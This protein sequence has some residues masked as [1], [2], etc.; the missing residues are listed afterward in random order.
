LNFVEVFEAEE[1]LLKRFLMAR[2]RLGKKGRSWTGSKLLH[3][4]YIIFISERC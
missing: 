4:E 3:F 2:G 1:D